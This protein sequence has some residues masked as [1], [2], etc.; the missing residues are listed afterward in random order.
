MLFKYI[1]KNTVFLSIARI[2]FKGFLAGLTIILARYLGVEKFGQYATAIAFSGLFLVFNDLGMTAFLIRE[3]SRDKSKLN[4]LAGNGLLVE[5][6]MS[7]LLFGAMLL[8]GRILNYS[9]LILTLIALFGIGTL[10]YEARKV[11]QGV[12]EASLKFK[13]IAV[14]QLIYSSLLFFL[15]LFV[16]LVKPD[17]KNVA[18]VQIFVSTIIII[19]LTIAFFRII[20]PKIDLRQIYPMLSGAFAFCLS[21]LFF[22]IYFQTDAVI[23]SIFKTDKDVGLYS[24]VY[25]LVIAL[26]IFPQIIFRTCMPV[27]YGFGFKNMEK[28]KR[29]YKAILKY[30]SAAG[31]ACSLGM[32]FLAKPILIL[33]YGKKYEAAVIILQILAWFVF[34][35]FLSMTFGSYLL[36]T[37]K[38]NRRAAFQGVAALLNLGLNLILIPKWGFLAAAGTTLLSDL[39][40]AV[41]YFLIMTRDFKEKITFLMTPI[42]RSFLAAIILSLFLFFTRDYF[43]V[44]VSAILGAFV[45]GISLWI[46]RFFDEYDR[47]LIRQIIK[48]DTNIR[49]STNDTN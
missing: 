30:L 29:I 48:R 45:F 36:S 38:Q 39:F 37:D 9:S 33:A 17:F 7:I 40:L 43:H 27:I 24:A 2:I 42:L 6:I 16:L 15:T 32:F 41:V 10:L 18:Y 12:F 46:F 28:L 25:K 26:F 3:G 22:I 21:Q 4:V 14:Q 8:V 49:M 13:I 34:I 35:K 23:L 47:K 20:K 44:I 19:F 1:F 5:A 31:L 11:F